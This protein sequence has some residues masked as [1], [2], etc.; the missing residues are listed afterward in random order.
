MK[1]QSAEPGI[2]VK[3]AYV[4]ANTFYEWL[5]KCLHPQSK[6]LRLNA[7]WPSPAMIPMTLSQDSWALLILSATLGLFNSHGLFQLPENQCLPT[8]LLMSST[9]AAIPRSNLLRHGLST[10]QQ[11]TKNS[12]APMRR[13]VIR[14]QRHAMFWCGRLHSPSSWWIFSRGLLSWSNLI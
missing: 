1:H 8:I 13:S 11:G 14:P 3:W 5:R 6:A 7:Y 10:P 2:C 12:P 9:P 4:C